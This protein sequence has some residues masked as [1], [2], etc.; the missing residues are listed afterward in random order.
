MSLPATP[1]VFA[2]NEHEACKPDYRQADAFY[3][4]AHLHIVPMSASKLACAKGK[5]FPL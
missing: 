3:L 2:F 4:R 1:G 5:Y